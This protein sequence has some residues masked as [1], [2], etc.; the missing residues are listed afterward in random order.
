[1]Q[2][3][4]TVRLTLLRAMYL[5]IGV[6]LTLTIGP[7]IVSPPDG[8]VDAR[9]VARA[10]LGAL[11]LL[12]LLGV[13]HPFRMLP[14][15]MFELVWKLVWVLAF[16]LPAWWRGGMEP[17]AAET[18]VAC[19]AGVVMVPLV[20]PWRYVVAHYVPGRSGGAA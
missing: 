6:G 18:L 12:S 19:L 14:I 13:R 16:G 15:M 9:T 2:T 10:L 8:P 20:L 11:A 4:G 5:L 3:I 1:M 17:Y 7:L